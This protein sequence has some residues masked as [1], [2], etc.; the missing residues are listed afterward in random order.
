[1]DI[2]M[3]EVTLIPTYDCTLNCRLC[4]NNVPYMHSEKNVFTLEDI[5]KSMDRYFEI[6]SFVKMVTISGGEPQLFPHLTQVI[7]HVKKYESQFDKCRMVTNGT[8]VPKQQVLDAMRSLGEKFYVLGDD[9]G[10]LCSKRI[11]ELDSVLTENQIQHII[12]NYRE[13]EA[14]RGGWV[15]FGDHTK[16]KHTEEGSERLYAICASSKCYPLSFGKLWSCTVPQRRYQLGLG[17]DKSEYVD[18]LDDSISVQEQQS[19][20]QAM[21]EKKCLTAC[22]YCNGLCPD[23]ERFIPAEQLTPEEIQCVRSGARSYDEVQEMLK[24]RS[25]E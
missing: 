7:R 24:S 23:S 19:K 2:V 9:Y 17:A 22:A 14:Y 11:R 15:N 21:S 18:L 5:L 4:G 1:M 12:R 16:K 10:I 8:L 6:V 13:G 25:T 3:P 20:L